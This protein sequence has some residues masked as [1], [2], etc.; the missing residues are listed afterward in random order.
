MVR[1]NLRMLKYSD[2]YSTVRA[3]NHAHKDTAQ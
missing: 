1:Q 3:Y 2:T